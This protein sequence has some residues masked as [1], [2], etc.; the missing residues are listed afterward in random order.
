LAKRR[1]TVKILGS[2]DE[3]MVREV[4]DIYFEGA[5]YGFNKR[6]ER[7]DETYKKGLEDGIKIGDN[8]KRKVNKDRMFA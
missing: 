1:K 6:I 5:K 8:T 3:D 2:V 4:C 7:E